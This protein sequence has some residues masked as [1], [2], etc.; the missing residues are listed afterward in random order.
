MRILLIED[1]EDVADAV[2]HSFR[3]GGHALDVAADLAQAED[4]LAVQDFDLL[5]LDLNLP[6][7][8]GL[9]LLQRVR[10]RQATPV[11][12]L[13]ARDAI[14]ERV[15]ALDAGADDY[16]VKPFDLR[17]LEARARVLLRRRQDAASSVQSYGALM[18]DS[19][20][21]TVAHQGRDLGLTRREFRLLEILLAARGKAIDKQRIL[22]K[23]FAFDDSAALNT[24]DVY[25]ARL[26]KR[27]QG[28]GVTVQTMRGFGF[29]LEME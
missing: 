15:A 26:R 13:T 22:D 27:L 20:N 29:R 8:S 6:D 25:V 28:S 5:I 11:L 12:I 3:R 24:V 1:A 2:A 16:L 4:A 9:D 14:E 10:R 18:I 21:G 17:E 7:G 19:A 23:L